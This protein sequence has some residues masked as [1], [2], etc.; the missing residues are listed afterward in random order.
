M[1]LTPYLVLINLVLLP[2]LQRITKKMTENSKHNEEL[3]IDQNT[4]KHIEVSQRSDRRP[5]KFENFRNL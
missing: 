5:Q 2:G 1:W 4:I 3:L